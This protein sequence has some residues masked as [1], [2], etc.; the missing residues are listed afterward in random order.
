M[1]GASD[2]SLTSV[3]S[4]HGRRSPPGSFTPALVSDSRSIHTWPS[5]I[6]T[7]DCPCGTPLIET[8]SIAGCCSARAGAVHASATASVVSARR[9]RRARNPAMALAPA[10]SSWRVE[11]ALQRRVRERDVDEDRLDARAVL[12]VERQRVAPTAVRR[13]YQPS[14]LWSVTTWP[15]PA[16]PRTRRVC[17]TR[18]VVPWLSTWKCSPS[19]ARPT[20]LTV[21]CAELS[22][23]RRRLGCR[24]ASA[25]GRRWICRVRSSAAAAPR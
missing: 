24:R 22:R 21:A 13:M 18:C 9:I 17:G 15:F 11:A 20:P 19:C 25:P 8:S 1:R 16:R 3:R 12:L 5:S 14:A 23:A 7:I 2:P 4:F 6:T 10:R